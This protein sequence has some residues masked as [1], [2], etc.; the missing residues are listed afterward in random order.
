MPN[1]ASMAGMP[2][3][4][5]SGSNLAAMQQQGF[6]PGGPNNPAVMDPS[7]MG[8]SGGPPPLPTLDEMDLSIQCN[9]NFLR[10][11]VTKIVS[12]QT[13]ANASRLPLGVVCKPMWNDKG[14]T[15]D[16][17]DVVDFGAAGIIRCKR[18]RTYINPFVSWADNGRRWR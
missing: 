6:T 13:Q 4:F 12:T 11:S 8:S 15:N 1:P 7:M 16:D 17:I 18:C 14:T 10:A 3:G 9:P 2:M 5:D